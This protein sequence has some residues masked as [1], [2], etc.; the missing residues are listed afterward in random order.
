MFKGQNRAL[1][2][3]GN[4]II[5]SFV[6]LCKGKRIPLCITKTVQDEGLG[7]LPDVINRYFDRAGIKAHPVRHHVYLKFRRRFLDLVKNSKYKNIA[8]NIGRIEV[9]YT[10]FT[11]QTEQLRKLEE[12]RGT[13]HRA[14]LLPSKKDMIILGEAHTLSQDHQLYFI[15]DDGDFIKFK[16]EIEGELGVV[17]VE[18]LDLPKFATTLT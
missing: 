18:L 15:T 16:D 5:S 13:K 3:V 10:G 2:S 17:V 8:S 14:S 4:E 11:K 6:G 9:M 1:S 12:L 7:K